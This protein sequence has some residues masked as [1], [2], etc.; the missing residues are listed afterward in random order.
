MANVTFSDSVSKKKNFFYWMLS[1]DLDN[2][3]TPYFSTNT[4][5]L[6]S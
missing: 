2:L 6:N 4:L 5:G 1:A 3:M